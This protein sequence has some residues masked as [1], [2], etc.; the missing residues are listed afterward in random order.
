MHKIVLDT[1]VFIDWL[2]RGLH[3]DWVIGRAGGAVRYLSSVVHME[4]GLG[5]DTTRRR[6]AVD[7]IRDAFPGSRRLSPSPAG[8]E[9]AAG[10]FRRLHGDGLGVADRLSAMDDILIALTAREI[11][12]TVVTSNAVEFG[13]IAKELP[14]LRVLVPVRETG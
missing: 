9:E 8:F 12:A 1:N 14:G 13:R 4:L 3:E 5:A 2:R 6:R 11:G 10:V 7:R